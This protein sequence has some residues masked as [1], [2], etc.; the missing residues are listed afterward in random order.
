MLKALGLDCSKVLHLGRN[1]GAKYLEMGM[2]DAE[3]IRQ[4]GQWA[5]GVFDTSYSTKLPMEAIRAL[6][7]FFG[8]K[9]SAYFL[10][11]ST[12]QP[13]KELLV[14][15]PIGRWVSAAYEAVCAADKKNEHPP[16][17]LFL[18]FLM[19]LNEVFL[20]DAAAML[21]LHP[22]RKDHPIFTDL[23]CFLGAEF[24]AFQEEMRVALETAQDP[25]DADL[26]RVLPGV[27]QWHSANNAEVRQ[28]SRKLD[29]F[30]EVLTEGIN[31]LIAFTQTN[32]RRQQH[33][34]ERLAQFLERGAE[35]LRNR[36]EEDF[37]ELLQGAATAG[38]T[39]TTI[40]KP[41]SPS[42][43][44]DDLEASGFVA[45]IGD[46]MV[47]DNGTYE[48]EDNGQMEAEAAAGA[49]LQVGATRVATEQYTAKELQL[50]A[51]IGLTKP[52]KSFFMRPKHQTLSAML[53]EWIGRADFQ[54]ELG[55]VE[56]REQQ[57]KNKWRLH[58]SAAQSAHY[59]R[60]K[61]IITGIRAYGKLHSM[62]EDDACAALQDTY[63]KQCKCY[64][65]K[66][67]D[68]MQENN[69]TEKKA[70]RGRLKT[71]EKQ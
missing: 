30:A 44:E 42:Q 46:P 18:K 20:Q 10:S 34:D 37:T 41:P 1:L 32:E 25:A 13:K 64:V 6:A 56:G 5:A 7:G 58:W 71:M 24:K 51:L 54:D 28:V 2:T 23:D 69:L 60:T 17:R 3:L 31:K 12:V 40:N 14:Q 53:D 4:M 35:A 66:M 68:Y 22:E 65:S 50:G 63:K 67:K 33:R 29:S 8:G 11:R 49:L 15:T 26:Q 62:S 55:G 39:D 27:H 70:R 57:W 59:S 43:L 61:A 47:V 19:D 36:E 52:N 21:I 38:L 45:P 48:Y 9:D 16:V